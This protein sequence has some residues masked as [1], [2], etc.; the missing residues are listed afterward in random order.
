MSELWWRVSQRVLARLE[1]RFGH[2]ATGAAHH[3][4]GYIVDELPAFEPQ[5]Q[6]LNAWLDAV[7]DHHAQECSDDA[8]R[9][10][11]AVSAP[12]P[13]SGSGALALLDARIYT[14]ATPS[15]YSARLGQCGNRSGASAHPDPT[16]GC[17]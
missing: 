10:A 2:F 12:D 11:P 9:A 13:L 7:V 16:L 15:E 1:L 3:V 4:L 14:P 6:P 5:Q 17:P 8:V